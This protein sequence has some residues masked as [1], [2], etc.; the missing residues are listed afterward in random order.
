MTFGQAVWGATLATGATAAGSALAAAAES[1]ATGKPFSEAFNRN[2]TAAGWT[3]A[4]GSFAAAAAGGLVAAGANGPLQGYVQAA[5]GGGAGL[6]LGAAAVFMGN[7]NTPR[8][9]L[10]GRTLAQ[11][12]RGHTIQFI[13]LSALGFKDPWIPYLVMGGAGILGGEYGFPPGVW[14][15][16]LATSLGAIW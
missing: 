3:L 15:E 9:D 12:E 1:G 13:G 2:F 14:W 4:G 6:T 11:H 10:G 8:P 16:D 5:G 7:A